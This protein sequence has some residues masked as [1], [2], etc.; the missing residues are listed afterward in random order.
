[1]KLHFS[2]TSTHLYGA[3]EF[4]SP[5]QTASP[6]PP[7]TIPGIDRALLMQVHESALTNNA[8]SLA[9]R[10]LNEP[11]FRELV[12]DTLALTPDEPDR[13]RGRVPAKV[14]LA[15]RDPIELSLQNGLVTIAFHITAFQDQGKPYP[16]KRTI[17]V[18]YR[19]RIGAE[20]M[21]LVREGA[22][23][24]EP[25]NVA[26]QPDLTKLMT[27]VLPERADTQGSTTTGSLAASHNLK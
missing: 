7:P 26:D 9:G 17:R 14:T 19:P 4:A 25:A 24:V 2:S 18:N 16:G 13:Q 15:A 20:G 6:S 21:E 27:E 1:P 10:T 12:F 5:W 22:V 23:R 8:G 3:S 11:D